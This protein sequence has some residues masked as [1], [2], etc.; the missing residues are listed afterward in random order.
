M[1]REHF[2]VLLIF[3]FFN[4][5]YINMKQLSLFLAFF[6]VTTLS[7]ACTDDELNTAIANGDFNEEIKSHFLDRNRVNLE[8]ME[9]SELKIYESR[10]QRYAVIIGTWRKEGKNDGRAVCTRV[11]FKTDSNECTIDYIGSL[12]WSDDKETKQRYCQIDFRNENNQILYSFFSSNQ[13]VWIVANKIF[14][15]QED[16]V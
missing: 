16:Q 8:D 9:I 4:E 13:Y 11:F 2:F 15:K 1:K 14:I 3:F 12:H 7:F 6:L 5:T 10:E